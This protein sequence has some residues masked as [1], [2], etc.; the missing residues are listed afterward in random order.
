MLYRY[1]GTEFETIS[2]HLRDATAQAVGAA[3]MKTLGTSEG[4]VRVDKPIGPTGRSAL[5]GGPYPDCPT[6]AYPATSATMRRSN[7]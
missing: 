6:S 3:S 1:T 7:R 5:V 2:G 4:D